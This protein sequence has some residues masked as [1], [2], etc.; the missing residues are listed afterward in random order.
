MKTLS[1][2]TLA[3]NIAAVLGELPEHPSGIVITWHG[4]P[5]ARLIPLHP[6]AGPASQTPVQIAAGAVLRTL[7]RMPGTPTAWKDV[8]PSHRRRQGATTAEVL[9]VLKTMPG[10]SVE[11]APTR[12]GQGWILTY[13]DDLL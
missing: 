7:Q 12:N 13:E 3:G 10:V 1:S 11:P 2:S 4:Q 8:R 6:A 5:A 9:D